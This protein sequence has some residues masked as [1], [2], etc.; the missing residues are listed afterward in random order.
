MKKT[1]AAGLAVV[2]LQASW[3]AA[4]SL[5]LGVNG[6][7]I[8]FGNSDVWHGLRINLVD[9]DVEQVTGL[10]VSLWRPDGNEDA[11]FE[12]ITFGLLGPEAERIT[13]LGIGGLGIGVDRLD[14]IALAGIG[15]GAER[16]SGI[17]LAGVGIGAEHVEG[18]AIAPIG[19]GAGEGVDGIVVF[20]LL[21]IGV[22]NGRAPRSQ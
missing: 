15:I 6:Y 8:S 22:P 12:G 20:R 13:G 9:R 10:N 16:V 18:L 3:A 5:D 11:H 21:S 17:A 14:G 4:G 1:L 7:G 2:L 19:V